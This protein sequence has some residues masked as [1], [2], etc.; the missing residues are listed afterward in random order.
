MDEEILSEIALIDGELE[1][2]RKQ[3]VL[4]RY[5]AGRRKHKKQMA[6]HRCKKR[7]R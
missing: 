5:N 7:N 3:N 4:A 1:R 2:R 6:F